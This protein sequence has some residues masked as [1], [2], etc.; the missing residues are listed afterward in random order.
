MYYFAYGSNLNKKQMK[1]RCPNSKMVGSVILQGYKLLFRN[2]ENSLPGYLTIQQNNDS[3]VP[4]GVYEISENDEKLLDKYE[5]VK[6]QFY[7]KEIITLKFIH[8]SI[9]GLI[10]IMNNVQKHKPTDEYYN[11]VKTG[12]EEWK[13]DIQ[14]LNT[15]CKECGYF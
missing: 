9:R 14:Y 3:E 4:I 13:F 1:E 8:K 12:Y 15:A 10:Y 5:G 7:R 2:Y 11:K 6:K